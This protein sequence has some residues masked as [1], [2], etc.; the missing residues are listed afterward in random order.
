MKKDKPWLDKNGKMRPD[1][2]IT[3]LGAHWSHDTW[4][5]YYRAY[6]CRKKKQEE[7]L[8]HDAQDVSRGLLGVPHSVIAKKLRVAL[9]QLTLEQRLIVDA[10]LHNKPNPLDATTES[11]KAERIKN[12]AL[13]DLKRRLC[14]LVDVDHS[15]MNVSTFAWFIKKAKNKEE[16]RPSFLTQQ[17]EGEESCVSL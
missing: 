2:E 7:K 15:R 4:R 9:N 8:L 3:K 1:A 13:F 10:I 11:W 17:I 12:R 16:G 5:R 14:R 6:S